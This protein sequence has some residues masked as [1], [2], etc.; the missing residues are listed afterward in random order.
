[1]LEVGTVV[2]NVI[3]S[4]EIGTSELFKLVPNGTSINTTPSEGFAYSGYDLKPYAPINYKRANSGSPPDLIVTWVRRTR[5]GGGLIDGSDTAPLYEDSEAYEAYILPNAGAITAFVP[6]DALTYT[7]AYTGLS[8]ATLTYTAAQQATDGFTA[9]TDT[10]YLA[11]YQISGTVGRGFRG[12]Q[13]LPA[14]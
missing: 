8:S 7:R 5:I 14:F 3:T 9:A 2:G 11:V 10:L 4:A 13:A 12:Y 6:T 1:M